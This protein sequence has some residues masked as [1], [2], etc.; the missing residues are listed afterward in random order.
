[1][2]IPQAKED[3]WKIVLYICVFFEI[4]I[5]GLLSI[6]LYADAF[7]FPAYQLGALL[8]FTALIYVAFLKHRTVEA[9]EAAEEERFKNR[10]IIDSIPFGVIILDA[11]DEM[12]FVN[13]MAKSFLGQDIGSSTTPDLGMCL[14]FDIMEAIHNNQWGGYTTRGLEGLFDVSV[15]ISPI[16]DRTGELLGKMLVFQGA[17]APQT[18]VAQN[19][20][21]SELCM[22]YVTDT[23]AVFRQVQSDVAHEA[24]IPALLTKNALNRKNLLD[25][26]DNVPEEAGILNDVLI[27]V[28]TE[29]KSAYAS[30][31]LSIKTDLEK[32]LTLQT[33]EIF[34]QA[35]REIMTNCLLFSE[36]GRTVY[37]ASRAED[38][39]YEIIIRD[40]GVGMNEELLS[41]AQE[42]GVVGDNSNAFPQYRRGRGLSAVKTLMESIGGSI[43]IESEEGVGTRVVLR[44]KIF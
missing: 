6:Q 31:K 41:T 40:E 14:P 2:K 42:E 37:I 23:E 29:V 32:K 34:V 24:R 28:I 4:I 27:K 5:I 20:G 43:S 15:A 16:K 9:T 22:Q 38:D 25:N 19:D 7:Q 8:F 33:P 12:V 36:E 18:S 11:D 10:A 39:F 13:A 3:R 17:G 35:L 44:A 30:K 26:L 1:M 21:S